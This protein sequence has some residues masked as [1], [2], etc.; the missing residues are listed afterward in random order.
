MASERTGDALVFEG[1]GRVGVRR[2]SFPPPPLGMLRIA[3]RACGICHRER[4]VLSGRLPRAFPV[5]MGHEPIGVVDAVGGNVEGFVAGQWVT[6]VG[7]ASLASYDLVDARHVAVVGGTGRMELK[8]G[9]PAMCAVNAV[10]RLHPGHAPTVAVNGVGFMGRLLVQ[11]L[12]AKLP[13]A[14]VLAVDPDSR[15]REAAIG[16]GADSAYASLENL[17][18]REA[19]A[20][21]VFEASGAPGTLPAAMRALRNGGTLALFAHHFSVEPEV[22]SEWHMRGIAVLNT[23]PWS[24]PDL[25]AEVREAV[26]L[27]N[28]GVLT[29]PESEVE[30]VSLRQAAEI[31][32]AGRTLPRKLVVMPGVADFAGETGPECDDD[33]AQAAVP[34]ERSPK[35]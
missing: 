10:N 9:E 7:T 23:V 12:R 30:C 32:S 13:A 34:V 1:V 31:L 6:G 35:A 29:I 11:A 16:S 4:H 27:L 26:D 17:P 18:A 3:V 25:G 14:T 20:D 5:V 2:R 24:A 8:L 21:I 28:R 22:V 33:R 15:R 19:R